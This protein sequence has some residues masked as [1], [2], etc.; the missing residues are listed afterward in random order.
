MVTLRTVR[1]VVFKVIWR[2]AFRQ[3]KSESPRVR[4]H[5]TRNVCRKFFARQSF[6]KSDY[7]RERRIFHYPHKKRKRKVREIEK[8]K[9]HNII[10]KAIYRRFKNEV[11]SKMVNLAN[12]EDATQRNGRHLFVES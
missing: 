1:S 2:F 4:E 12:G 5:W 7:V 8:R 10:R 11:Q 6:F 3:K 9:C